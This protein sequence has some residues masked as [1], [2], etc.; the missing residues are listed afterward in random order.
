MWRIFVVIPS[1]CLVT[2]CIYCALSAIACF[3]T[4]EHSYSSNCVQGLSGPLFALKV[5]CIVNAWSDRQKPMSIFTLPSPTIMFEISEMLILLEKR[6]FLYHLAG[7]LTGIIYCSISYYWCVKRFPGTGIRLSDR[8]RHQ[9]TQL[10]QSDSE[11]WTRSW[12][13]GSTRGLP[14]RRTHPARNTFFEHNIRPSHNENNSPS[15]STTNNSISSSVHSIDQMPMQ[16]SQSPPVFTYGG[17]RTD[18]RDITM[19][20]PATT[21]QSQ[22]MSSQTISSDQSSHADKIEQGRLSVPNSGPN[23][24][25][26]RDM[27]PEPS[28]FSERSPPQVPPELLGGGT[29]MSEE[30]QSEDDH[31]SYSYSSGSNSNYSNLSS[32]DQSSSPDDMPNSSPL[33]T[34][35]EEFSNPVI[36]VEELRRRRVERF[37]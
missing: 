13:Y 12:G 36:G 9:T 25:N 14:I 16:E 37:S 10:R 15:H 17:E 27:R 2:S 21:S 32:S 34:N 26:E 28:Y 4:E 22:A 5:I 1:V 19:S 35:R 29:Y 7:V 18:E 31:E 11:L 24:S 20:P 8:S 6:T 30:S 23:G 33:Q 3:I